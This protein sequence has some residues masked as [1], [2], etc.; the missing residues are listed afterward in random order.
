MVTDSDSR[1][2]TYESDIY[3]DILDKIEQ[4]E[5]RPIGEWLDFYE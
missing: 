3:Q 2:G 5:L 4:E 1:M